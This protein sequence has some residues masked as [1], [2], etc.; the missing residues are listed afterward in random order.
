MQAD[1]KIAFL[2]ECGGYFGGYDAVEVLETDS[3]YKLR[4]ARGS[5]GAEETFADLPE[6]KVEK[7]RRFVDTEVNGRWYCR[8]VDLYVL[9]GT[10][11]RLYDGRLE[12]H[13]SNLF[14]QGF[15][16]LVRFLSNELGCEGLERHGDVPEVELDEW[17]ELAIL[18]SYGAW[19]PDP[20]HQK[21]CGGGV[22]GDLDDDGEG[23]EGTET[24]ARQLHHDLYLFLD[25]YP[26][27]KDYRRILAKNGMPLDV[28]LIKSYDVSDADPECIV[29]MVL[30]IS[31]ADRFSGLSDNFGTC[32][33]DGTFGK[34]LRRLEVALAKLSRK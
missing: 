14:P 2:F 28:G 25:H 34:W 3:G 4:R 1:P 32:A 33:K 23:A 24:V 31:R 21:N 13:G 7:L 20:E 18:A 19:L 26:R 12:R 11:W 5:F 10:Q 22:E 30:A 27:Y 16:R 17:D 9:D 29:A 15:G 8:Y 6:A